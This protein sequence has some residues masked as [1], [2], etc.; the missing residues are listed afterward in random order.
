MCTFQ[1]SSLQGSGSSFSFSATSRTWGQAGLSSSDGVHRGQRICKKACDT[2]LPLHWD[3]HRIRI[4]VLIVQVKQEEEVP[5]L[6]VPATQLIPG[7]GSWGEAPWVGATLVCAVSNMARPVLSWYHL[8][9]VHL[10]GISPA[11]GTKRNLGQSS[12]P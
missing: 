4:L 7:A 3:L 11:V 8:I 2:P 5:S 10:S 12:I 9:S 6:G 1:L